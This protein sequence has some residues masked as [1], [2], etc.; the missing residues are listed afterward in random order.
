M[1]LKDLIT[2]SKILQLIWYFCV[3]LDIW[4]SLSPKA[5]A[6]IE[7]KSSDKVYHMLMYLILGAVPFLFSNNL[8]KVVLFVIFSLSL[9]ITLECLQYFVPNREFSLLDILANEV[10]ILLALLGGTILQRIRVD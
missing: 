6:P 9:G 4:L 5:T 1:R 8:R 10:G 3:I 7:F 2:S